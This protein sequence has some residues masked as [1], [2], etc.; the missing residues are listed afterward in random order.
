MEGVLLLL[1]WMAPPKRHP[2]VS[3]RRVRREAVWF[4]VYSMSMECRVETD[5]MAAKDD[6]DASAS[7]EAEGADEEGLLPNGVH[8][9]ATGR[10]I[11][12]DAERRRSIWSAH[13]ANRARTGQRRGVHWAQR[14]PTQSLRAAGDRDLRVEV[15]RN[16]A[17]R[18]A[19][20]GRVA[21]SPGALSGFRSATKVGD[22][23]GDGTWC[24]RVGCQTR[25]TRPNHR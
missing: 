14:D 8:H 18:I 12:G 6:R 3:S 22:G 23:R 25:R 17:N 1:L 20:L 13:Y 24:S 15:G 19:C 11:S 21:G 10:E 5:A 9:I 2:R 4:V 16:E 7:R